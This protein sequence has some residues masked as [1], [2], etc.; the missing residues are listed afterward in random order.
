ME[1][2]KEFDVF[3]TVTGFNHCPNAKR[4]L[5]GDKVILCREY[6]N[7]F[8]KCAI[9]VYSEFGKV[10][11][12]ANKEKTIRKGTLGA[13]QLA[14][15][16]GNT[17]TACVIEGGYYE[18]VCQVL[19]VF[20]VDKMILKAL[21]FYNEGEYSRALP[22]LLKIGEKYESLLLMQYTADCFIKLGKYKESLKFA[23]RAVNLEKNNKI[24]LMMYATALH[25]L[26]KYNEAIA[27]YSKILEIT[28]N[29]TVKQALAECRNML[30][31]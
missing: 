10:G 12:V 11:Y 18:A 25:K 14:E 20:D 16:M 27:I 8:D 1:H 5:E 4:L 29:E 21:G 22:L 9:S 3:V 31:K 13:T 2:S 6:E 28:E 26:E 19:D 15:I 23:E 24:S 30:K 17:A 7:E